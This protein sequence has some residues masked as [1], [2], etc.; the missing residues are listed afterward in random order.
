MVTSVKL[1]RPF[2]FGQELIS[3]SYGKGVLVDT[4]EMEVIRIG[5]HPLLHALFFVDWIVPNDKRVLVQEGALKHVDCGN[6]L[7]KISSNFFKNYKDDGALN[8]VL[9][10]IVDGV[11][12][13]KSLPESLG[14]DFNEYDSK[15]YNYKHSELATYEEIKN[16]QV[17]GGFF[18]IT[19]RLGGQPTLIYFGKSKNFGKVENLRD[20]LVLALENKFNVIGM[21]V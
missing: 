7:I 11:L 8:L 18:Y 2:A 13:G 10:K 5:A 9:S 19:L 17:R 15:F 1:V 14:L 4:P 21:Q 6:E 16:G 20:K 3:Y 12:H